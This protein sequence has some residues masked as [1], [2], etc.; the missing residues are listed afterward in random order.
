MLYNGDEAPLVHQTQIVRFATMPLQHMGYVTEY[1][2]VGHPLPERDLAGE[3]A[4][5]VLWINGPVANF[6]PHP[7]S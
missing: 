7:V 4:G 2:D 5:I 6:H 1:L 3:V